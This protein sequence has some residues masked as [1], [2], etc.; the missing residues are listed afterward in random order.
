M[1]PRCSTAPA[2]PSCSGGSWGPSMLSSRRS[3]A[4]APRTG[5]AAL[6]RLVWV[7]WG[8]AEWGRDGAGPR[9]EGRGR[10]EGG[11]GCRET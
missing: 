10:T 11:A 9:V 3:S 4:L 6:V 1:L 8:G 5:I 2:P 7:W